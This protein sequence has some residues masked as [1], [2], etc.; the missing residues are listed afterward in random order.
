MNR[1]DLP[2]ELAQQFTERRCLVVAAKTPWDL[3]AAAGSADTSIGYVELAL[4]SDDTNQFKAVLALDHKTLLIDFDGL[5]ECLYQAFE[6]E[7]PI[8]YASQDSCVMVVHPYYPHELE[9]LLAN[10]NACLGTDWND[11]GLS[12]EDEIRRRLR[13]NLP[14]NVVV[15]T[16][17]I[18]LSDIATPS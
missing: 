15:V 2:H 8:I 13:G 1:S 12:F 3:A 17:C 7:F 16:S 4:Q 5:R 9:T 11:A 6:T 14:R 10:A 18:D